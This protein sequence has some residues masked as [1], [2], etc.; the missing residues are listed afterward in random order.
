ML[1]YNVTYEIIYFYNAIMTHFDQDIWAAYLPQN[2]THFEQRG[3]KTSY[4]EKKDI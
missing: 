2:T 1:F 4:F 3:K